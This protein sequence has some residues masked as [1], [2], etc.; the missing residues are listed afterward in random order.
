ML[1]VEWKHVLLDPVVYQSNGTFRVA[2]VRGGLN[3]FPIPMGA[4]GRWESERR[5]WA[6]MVAGLAPDHYNYEGRHFN[7]GFWSI[8]EFLNGVFSRGSSNRTNE[9]DVNYTTGAIRI[10]ATAIYYW[11]FD[12]GEGEHAV[13]L[14]A[15]DDTNQQFIAD[16]FVDVIPDDEVGILTGEANNGRLRTE[17]IESAVIR[18]RTPT[19]DNIYLQYQFSRWSNE[20]DLS[21]FGSETV[22]TIKG[23]DIRIRRS[24][25]IAALAHYN[26]IGGAAIP[27]VEPPPEGGHVIMVGS[28][29]Y[30]FVPLLPIGGPPRPIGDPDPLLLA[31]LISSS[32]VRQLTAQIDDLQKRIEAIEKLR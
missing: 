16:D 15:F 5:H 9:F 10:E 26:P 27:Q 17:M 18:A 28:Q 19:G 32:Q 14:D 13:F 24:S 4:S 31:T 7:F 3:A 22:P 8:K 29:L 20:Q 23:R 12:D 30:L 11:D 6:P 21:R 2:R 1:T 25:V